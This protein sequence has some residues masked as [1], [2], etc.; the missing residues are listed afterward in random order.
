VR[1]YFALDAGAADDESMGAADAE[2]AV[3]SGEAAGGVLPPHATSAPT[4]AMAARSAT[5]TMF[6]MIVF[7]SGPE[8]GTGRVAP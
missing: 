3:V 7:S 8:R 6:F 4:D 2:L 5:T 1:A